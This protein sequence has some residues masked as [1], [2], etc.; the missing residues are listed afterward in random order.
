[1]NEDQL[2]ESQAN[3]SRTTETANQGYAARLHAACVAKRSVV[4][5]G[6]DPRFEMLPSEFREGRAGS[7]A[8]RAEAFT[9]WAQELL[10]VVASLAPVVK[11][12]SAFFELLGSA[13]VAALESVIAAAKERGLLVILDAKR[14]DIGSTAAAYAQAHLADAGADALTVNAYL[15]RDTLEPFVA[16]CRDAGKGIYVLVKTSNPGSADFQDVALGD[17]GLVRDRVAGAVDA[18]GRECTAAGALATNAVTADT[19]WASVGAVVGATYPT[20]LADLR[21]KMPQAPLLIPGYG[22]QG[23]GAEDCRSGFGA[24]GLGAVV[25]SSRGITFAFGKGD[26]AERFGDA[27]WRGSVEEAARTMRDALNA[28]RAVPDGE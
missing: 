15:G 22:A 19:V 10:D 24:D 23:G 25:N 28:V 14:G 2:N 20:E 1:M 16:R 21:A 8:A 9:L 6:I 7:A 18:L 3:A 12:Q 13:G 5:V 27:G 4:C 17:G 26:H 11:P